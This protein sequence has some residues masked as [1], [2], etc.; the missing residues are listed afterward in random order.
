MRVLLLLALFICSQAYTTLFQ[1]RIAA[2]KSISRQFLF[3]SPEP[4]KNNSPAKKD[5]GGLFGNMGN[6]M[7]SMKKMQEVMKKS[8]TL[9]KELQETTV[10]GSDPSGQ[11]VVTFTGLA[12]PIGVKISD[13]LLSEGADA[14]SAATTQALLDAHAK[15]STLLVTRTQQLYQ[16]MGLPMPGGK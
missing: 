8:E 1:S 15:S 16:S 3:G 11:V 7:D 10:T 5:G 4:P 12:I 2:T 14:V 13:R 6:M 9:Q